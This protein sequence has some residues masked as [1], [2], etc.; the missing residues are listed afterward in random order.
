MAPIST[1]VQKENQNQYKSKN[2]VAV[3]DEARKKNDL[4]LGSEKK[5]KDKNTIRSGIQSHT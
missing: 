2:K 5:R 3:I 1:M 4:L